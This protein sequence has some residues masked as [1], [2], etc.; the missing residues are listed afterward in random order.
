METTHGHSSK[1]LGV[2]FEIFVVE[3]DYV[4]GRLLNPDILATSENTEKAEKQGPQ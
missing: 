1:Y 4:A 3:N 2:V